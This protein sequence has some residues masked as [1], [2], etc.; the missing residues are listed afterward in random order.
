RGYPRGDRARPLYSR[1]PRPGEGRHPRVERAVTRQP[2]IVPYGPGALLVDTPG[3]NPV[4]LAV[5]LRDLPGVV[6]A[7]PGAA[8]VLLT[9]PASDVSE[10]EAMA[11]LTRA[12]RTAWSDT[13]DDAHP[14]P[15]GVVIPARYDGEDLPLLAERAAMTIEDVIERHSRPEYRVAFM[16]FAPG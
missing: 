4:V 13:A 12:L 15:P 8:T 14:D 11:L 9:F 2:V 10:D 1:R 16:G 5:H 3:R 6:D 7:V